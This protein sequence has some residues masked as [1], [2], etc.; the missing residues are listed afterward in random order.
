ME[1][2]KCRRI[3]LGVFL[4][5]WWLI[6]TTA[7]AYDINFGPRLWRVRN[8]SQ[9][10][11]SHSW[12]PEVAVGYF[13]TIRWG[14]SEEPRVDERHSRSVNRRILHTTT[15]WAVD[16]LQTRYIATHTEDKVLKE[17]QEVGPAGEIRTLRLL[18]K[19]FY[20]NNSILGKRPSLSRV[21][22]YFSVVSI[23]SAVVAKLLPEPYA[24]LWLDLIED[25]QMSWT[26]Y[27][28]SIGVG[29]R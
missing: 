16:W 28:A 14:G 12:G 7:A 3:A 22:T 10:I 27:N 19:G 21:N 2:S 26:A 17:W 5:A 24:H 1:R 11:E 13:L 8:H 15:L 9:A 4:L 23:G 6:P 25:Q 18:K 20:E 29:L